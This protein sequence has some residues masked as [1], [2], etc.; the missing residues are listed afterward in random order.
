M[1]LDTSHPA[2]R[3]NA[4]VGIAEQYNVGVEHLYRSALARPLEEKEHAW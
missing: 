4:L 3:V 2:R 1:V